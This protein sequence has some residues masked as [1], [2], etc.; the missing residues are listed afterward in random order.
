MDDTE[1]FIAMMLWAAASTAAWFYWMK[2][3]IEDIYKDDDTL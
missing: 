3:M 1:F 2:W